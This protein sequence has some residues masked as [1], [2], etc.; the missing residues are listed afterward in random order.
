[1]PASAFSR[2]FNG[3]QPEDNPNARGPINKDVIEAAKNFAM[4][5]LALMQAEIAN[6]MYKKPIEAMVREIHYE[7]LPPEIRIAII[8]AWRRGSAL[9]PA[10]IESMVPLKEYATDGSAA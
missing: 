6:G 7:P 1:M 5:E 10:T 3:S 2:S 4:L 9:P 8:A